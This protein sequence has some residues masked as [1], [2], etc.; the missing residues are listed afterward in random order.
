LADL[1]NAWEILDKLDNLNGESSD[2][3]LDMF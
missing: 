2:L 1:I 3:T